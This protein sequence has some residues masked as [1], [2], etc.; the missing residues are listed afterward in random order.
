MLARGV[1]APYIW[2]LDTPTQAGEPDKMNMKI[3]RIAAIFV[4]VGVIGTLFAW[5]YGFLSPD[6]RRPGTSGIARIGGPFSLTDHN[7]VARTEADFKGKFQLIYFGYSYCPDVC[8]TALQVMSVALTDIGDKAKAVQP[9]FVTVDPERDTPA[10]LKEYVANFYPGLIGLT[11]T[12][13]QVKQAARA[14]RVYYRKAENPEGGTGKDY[15]M[16]H[17][18]IVFLMD[19]DGKYVTHFSH[20]TQPSQMAAEL[21]KHF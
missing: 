2:C 10:L 14:W 3:L 21:R 1:I 12:A 8:P 13:E 16:D 15:L 17:S 18:S 4:S 19:R 6:G 5:Q 9:L 20:Q 11:G 7:G